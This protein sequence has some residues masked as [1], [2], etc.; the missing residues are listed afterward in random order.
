[1]DGMQMGHLFL[2]TVVVP[3]GV[4]PVVGALLTQAGLKLVQI[5]MGLFQ[6]WKAYLGACCYGFLALI[7]LAYCLK[8]TSL[9]TFGSSAVQVSVFLVVPLIALPLLLRKRSRSAVV[10]E[11]VAV[12]LTNL[13]V[14]GLI[15]YL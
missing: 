11:A 15:W 7:P 12:V 3:F 2:K 13:A 14:F 1:M 8:Y 9:T 4:A 6:C 5:P 10:V